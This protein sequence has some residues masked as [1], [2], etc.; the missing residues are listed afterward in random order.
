MKVLSN[1]RSA[2]ADAPAQQPAHVILAKRIAVAAALLW[3]VSLM[4]PGYLTEADTDGHSGLKILLA[5]IP[6][7]WITTGYAVYANVFFL[8]AVPQLWV[9][10]IPWFSAVMMIGFAAS[11]VL[12][13]GHQGLGTGMSHLTS[14]GWGA[15]V[16]LSAIACA[17]SAVFVLIGGPARFVGAVILCA[18]PAVLAYI[19]PDY[20]TNY[21]NA[22]VQERA[23][24][25]SISML[26]PLVEICGAQLT[27]P[28]EAI[29]RPDEAISLDL[30]PR[31]TNFDYDH[32]L[33]YLPDLVPYEHDGFRWTRDK[34]ASSRKDLAKSPATGTRFTL[35]AR[36]LD[37]GALLELVENATGKTVYSQ[38]FRPYREVIHNNL[39]LCPHSGGFI[40]STLPTPHTAIAT[41]LG[42]QPR[43]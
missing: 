36:G 21:R 25:H 24:T 43:H 10:R 41:A 3:L 17:A 30:P 38:S 35:K 14:W 22:N 34:S 42:R 16:W 12:F 11:I 29:V 5:G 31:L 26:Y 40:G 28:V 15:F 1:L 2:L 37:G 7:G 4:L 33:L 32:A 13:R 18:P 23:S 8:L 20:I 6:F 19:A 9:G 27:W 39:I